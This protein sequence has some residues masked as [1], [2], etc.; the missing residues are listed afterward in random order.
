VSRKFL[1]NSTPFVKIARDLN[2][3]ASRPPKKCIF[4]DRPP[5]VVRVQSADRL[6]AAAKVRLGNHAVPDGSGLAFAAT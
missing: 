6:D 3:T 2:R 5:V 4:F 1:I